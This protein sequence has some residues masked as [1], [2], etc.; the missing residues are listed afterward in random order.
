MRSKLKEPQEELIIYPQGRFTHNS[1]PFV[2]RIDHGLIKVPVVNNSKKQVVHRVG[3]I[4]GHYEKG[5]VKKELNTPLELHNDLLSVRL[6]T[7][8]WKPSREIKG[9]NN[10]IA[11]ELPY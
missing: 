1:H 11:L 6:T 3:A 9:D 2:T 10:S 4:I 8:S 7:G 5:K